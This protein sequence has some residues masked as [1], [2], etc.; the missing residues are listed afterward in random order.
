MYVGNIQQ[1]EKELDHLPAPIQ[2]WIQYLST[3]DVMALT[4]GRHELEDGCYM[5][6]DLSRTEA[7]ES[8]KW[9][10]HKQYIDIQFVISGKERIDYIP[11]SG[12]KRCVEA[13]DE[14]DLFFYEAKEDSAVVPI[15][16]EEGRYAVF[17][18]EDIHR[19][20]C[21]VEDEED[22][23]KIVMKIRL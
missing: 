12:V 11:M 23:K 19:P 7:Q 6:V 14:R 2:R 8:R 15:F 5:N 16:M 9:E 18:P 21:K 22:V 20:L 13:Y 3:L 10:G 1:V 4:P 17:Y